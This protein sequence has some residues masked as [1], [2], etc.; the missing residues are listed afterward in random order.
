MTSATSA[1]RF[2][3]RTGSTHPFN[4]DGLEFFDEAISASPFFHRTGSTH[5]FNM[6]DLSFL[7]GTIERTQP[8]A[9]LTVLLPDGA[10]YRLADCI[11]VFM[12]MNSCP[13]LYYAFEH[14]SYDRLHADIEATSTTAVASLLRYL[15]TGTYFDADADPDRATVSLLAHVETYKIA[16]DFDVEE[17]QSQAK[18]NLSYQVEM[19]MYQP[20]PPHDLLET[21]HFVYTHHDSLKEA[22]NGECSLVSTL[23]SY[24]I[25]IFSTHHLQHDAAFRKLALDIPRLS[26]DLCHQVMKR[27]FE[28][29]CAPNIIQL[30]QEMQSL[31]D[32][33]QQQSFTARPPPTVLASRDLP[34]EMLSDCIPIEPQDSASVSG[35]QDLND[36]DDGDDGDDRISIATNEATIGI[37]FPAFSTPPLP[38]D[39]PLPHTTADVN[40]D[41]DMDMDMD[42]DMQADMS[43]SSS[44]SFSSFAGFTLVHRPKPQPQLHVVNPDPFADPISSPEED[45]ATSFSGI[46]M[47]SSLS[48][49]DTDADGDTD[50]DWNLV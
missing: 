44:S 23:L 11:D 43:S 33:Q 1:S 35:R 40:A 2:L 3:T 13:L 41:T 6:N 28:D 4:M 39:S 37:P 19:A 49:S 25:S 20:S 5:P 48:V 10:I 38:Y 14:R 12:F 32:H 42:M 9:T 16:K 18:G 21:I 24:C 26:Q 17:L 46:D 31:Q 47:P 8:K 22:D 34:R 15:Y 50:D 27:E 7:N 30:F 45:M 29:D 36:D